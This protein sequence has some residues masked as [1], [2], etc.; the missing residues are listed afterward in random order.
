MKLWFRF[1]LVVLALVAAALACSTGS[2]LPQQP[3]SGETLFE[4]DFSNLTSGWDRIQDTDGSTDYV[5]GKYKIIINIPNTDVWANPRKKFSNV[6]IRVIAAK[7]SGSND[8]HYG[9]ICR[10]LDANNFYFFVISSDGYYG[11]GKVKDGKHQLVNRE[12]MLPSEAIRQGEG[13]NTLQAVCNGSTLSLYVN[14]ELLDTQTDAEF[15]TGDV[16]LIA[17]TF[18]EAGVEVIFDDFRVKTP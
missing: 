11:I 16:G 14:N 8:N 9:V 15:T 2:P 17:G 4:D 1:S 3:A 12:E 13:N 18:G 5:D 10:Y 7:L 6:V